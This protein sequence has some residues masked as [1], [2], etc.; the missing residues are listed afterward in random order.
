[1]I[2]QLY[3]PEDA[4]RELLKTIRYI[5][6]QNTE[7]ERPKSRPKLPRAYAT[8]LLVYCDF[9]SEFKSDTAVEV[10]SEIG[11]VVDFN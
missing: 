9:S 10:C 5:V 7:I 11:G 4:P 2:L 8:N 3:H 1:M 6:P